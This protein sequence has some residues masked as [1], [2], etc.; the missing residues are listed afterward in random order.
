MGARARMTF[1]AVRLAPSRMEA[2]E[3]PMTRLEVSAAEGVALIAE[4]VRWQDAE[5]LANLGI[6]YAMS[7]KADS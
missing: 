4:N 7:P 3:I 1:E 6:H 5:K 2:L